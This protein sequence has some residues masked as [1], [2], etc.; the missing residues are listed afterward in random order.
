MKIKILFFLFFIALFDIMHAQTSFLGNNAGNNTFYLGWDNLVPFELNIQHQGNQNINILRN[1]LNRMQFQNQVN[2]AGLNG[3]GSP[4]ANRILVELNGINYPAWSILTLRE[5]ALT[6]FMR[7]DWFNIGTTCIANTDIM[8]VGLLER[9]HSEELNYETDAVIAWGCQ[10]GTGNDGEVDNFR[11]LFLRTEMGTPT[12]ASRTQQGR[13]VLRVTPL[14]NMGVGDFSSNG[15]GLNVQPT[16]KLDVDGTARFRQIQNNAPDVLFTGIEQDAVGDYELNYLAFNGNDDEFLAGDGTWQTIDATG[17]DCDW[18]EVG[19]NIVTGLPGS[20]CPIEGAV[21]I[22]TTGTLGKLNVD[23]NQTAPNQLY[24]FNF[25]QK[26]SGPGNILNSVAATYTE[27]YGDW[28]YSFGHNIRL[29]SPITNNATGLT[30]SVYASEAAYGGSFYTYNAN[31]QHAVIGDVK[32]YCDDDAYAIYGIVHVQED[33]PPTQFYDHWAGYFEGNVFTSGQSYGFSD[34]NLKNDIQEIESPLEI[35]SQLT[36]STYQYNSEEHQDINLPKGDQTGFIAQNVQESLPHA[37]REI[38]LP[39]L[40]DEEGNVTREAQTYLG[41]NYNQIIA[42][43]TGAIKEQQRTIQDLQTQ[44]EQL[45]Q[46]IDQL[47]DLVNACCANM[48]KRSSNTE[49]QPT[50]M[51]IKVDKTTLDQNIPN[52]FEVNTTINFHLAIEGKVIL[53]VL[54]QQGQVIEVLDE[55]FKTTGDYSVTWKAENLSSGVYF[56][57][58][59]I[60]GIEMVK[61][62]VKM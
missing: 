30:A 51:N 3:L 16:H 33:C 44:N 23:F 17:T 1:G 26:V 54:N 61:R 9:P 42:V 20:T 58:L 8:Y 7:R 55:G 41:V 34:Q 5:G 49:D 52:P 45:Q 10:D 21:S 4:N 31:L 28:N 53:K 50:D 57:S 2:W 6:S 22:G 27:I 38:K 48:E 15:F 35:I 11:M 24:P 37:V 47:T 13:E 19:P 36:P 62:A 56:Y 40:T 32:P 14:G 46:S 25:H 59:N 12:D 43:N 39:E 60:D 18:L 29:F